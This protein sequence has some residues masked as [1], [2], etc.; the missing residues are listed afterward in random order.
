MGL[1]DD[2]FADL[3]SG[4]QKAHDA[5]RRDLAR[6]R[7]GRA[8]VSLL[9]GIRVDYYGT[10]TPLNQMASL[11]TPDPR[12]IFVKPWDKSVVSAIEKAIRQ[13]DLGVNPMSDGELVRIPIPPLTEERRKDL[14]KIARKNGEESKVAIRGAR[15][16][17]RE[18]LEQLE[19]DGDVPADEVAQAL[20]KVETE[21]ETSVKKVDEIVANKEKEIMEV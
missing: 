20:K 16:E 15:R 11:S 17:A 21:I 9:D 10:P 14:V 2:V 1:I 6:L 7:T 12:T 4:I 8:S 5:L 19:S 13:S 3:R 18:L